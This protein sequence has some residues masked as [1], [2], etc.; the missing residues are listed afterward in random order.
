MV[1]PVARREPATGPNT[2][3]TRRIVERVSEI[4]DEEA[5]ELPPLYNA[6]DP[7]ALGELVDSASNH[8]QSLKITFTY[9]GHKVTV[10]ETGAVRVS[11][12]H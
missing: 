8:A 12:I 9:V 6:V 5:T 1:P 4:T 10:D 3:V 7:E 2:T 11:P